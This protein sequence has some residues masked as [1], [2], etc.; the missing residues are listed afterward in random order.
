MRVAIVGGGIIGLACAYELRRR[1]MEV[2][3]L[4]KG[5][6]GAA[7][8]SGNAGWIVPS[9]SGPLPTP[10]LK[11]GA[12]R[13]LF[14]RDSPLYI[15]PSALLR[16]SSWLWQFWRHC[17]QTDF[18]AGLEAVSQLNRETMDLYDGFREDGVQFEMHRAGLL[19]VFL[20]ESNLEHTLGELR[21][22]HGYGYE[23]PEPLSVGEL[24]AMEPA[25][26]DK[27]R[28]GFFVNRE[29]HVRPESLTAGLVQKL[30]EIGV[31]I[32]SPVMVHGGVWNDRTLLALV[33]SAG[34]VEADQFLIAAGAWSGK[35][36]AALGCRL[37]MEAGKGYSVTV[38]L[39]KIKVHHPLYLSEAKA[40]LTPFVGTHR[41]AGTLEL[42]G[43]NENLD[44]RRVASL[45]AATAEFV[46]EARLGQRSS[47]WVG[48]RPVTPDGLPLL[49]AVGRSD[50]LF[51]AAG[52]ALLGVTMAPAT[53]V[54]MADVMTNRKARPD[55]KPFDPMRFQ[56]KGFG[57]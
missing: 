56:K 23:R 12:L 15:K 57:S 21:R 29:R 13:W 1:G 11:L 14:R 3:I 43:V 55:L 22:L 50:N 34:R 28:G 46:P 39:P 36:S 6:P 41:I 35:I 2:T 4:E 30:G 47:S 38:D 25:L 16:L 27:V 54:A 26:S 33:T 48:M 20:K 32:R 44:H 17:N 45:L 18:E 40:A 19:F 10:D 37:P 7:C 9:L 5:K 8:S 51:V 24:A 49:G 31:E 52:H 42:S 53:S